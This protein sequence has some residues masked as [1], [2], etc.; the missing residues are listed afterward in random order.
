M[1]RGCKDTVT[2]EAYLW[3]G[4]LAL[5]ATPDPVIDTL[6]FAPCLFHTVVTIGLMAPVTDRQSE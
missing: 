1:S 6:R 3:H 4:C 5:E 2:V